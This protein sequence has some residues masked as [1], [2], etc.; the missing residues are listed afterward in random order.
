MFLEPIGKETESLGGFAGVAGRGFAEIGNDLLRLFGR[1]VGEVE[2]E[3]VR[4]TIE[5]EGVA[6]GAH[7]VEEFANAL[8]TAEL[9]QFAG[10]IN[11]GGVGDVGTARVDLHTEYGIGVVGGGTGGVACSFGVEET[12]DEV[13]DLLS[14]VFTTRLCCRAGA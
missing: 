14:V 4:R 1:H 3:F 13:V 11:D 9:R 10:H 2:G 8:L 6:L 7:V 5:A 12:F